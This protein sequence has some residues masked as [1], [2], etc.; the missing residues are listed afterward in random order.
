MWLEVTLL[1]RIDNRSVTKKIEQDNTVLKDKYCVSSVTSSPR[2]AA[3]AG[4]C[5]LNHR[6]KLLTVFS[7]LLEMVYNWNYPI[8][9][10]STLIYY[11]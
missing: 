8:C 11:M 7:I 6:A 4:A 1:N 3:F 10:E 9:I 2:I 5:Y